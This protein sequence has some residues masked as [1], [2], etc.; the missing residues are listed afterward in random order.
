MNNIELLAPAG[1]Y[2][3]FVAALLGGADAVYLSGE[4]FGARAYAKNFNTEELVRAIEM[5]HILNKKVYLTVNTLVKDDELSELFDYLRPFYKAG[6]DGVIVQDIGVIDLIGSCFPDL[7]VHA[8]TQLAVTSYEGLKL[9]RRLGVKR[10][11]LAR[12]LTLSE[13]KNIHNKDDM[14][15][16]CF[17]H[18]ALCY[19]YSGKCLFSSMI[20]GRSG[21][22]GRCAGSCRQPYN[23]EKYLLSTK[24][25][26]C[27]K[28]IPELIDAG[29]VS[30]KIE[31]RMKSPDY[32][33]GVTKIYRKYIDLYLNNKNKYSVDEIR[34]KVFKNAGIEKDFD[35]LN[36]LYTRGGNSEGY[37]MNHNGRHMISISD[38]SYKSEKLDNI[39]NPY[40]LSNANYSIIKRKITG[41]IRIAVSEPVLLTVNYGDY[42]VTCYGNV[43][44]EAS[45]RPLEE[46]TVKKQIYKTGDS[47]F[48]FESLICDID[49]NCFLRVSE[50]NDIRRNALLE[51]RNKILSHTYRDNETRVEPKT[52]D[53]DG[54]DDVN[55]LE[56][57]PVSVS[58]INTEQLKIVS[59]FD[60]I[61]RVY[62]PYSLMGECI[63]NGLFNIL[64]DNHK[65]IFISFPS[66]IRYDY[67]GNNKNN[68][69]KYLDLSDGVLIDNNELLY[70]LRNE[71]YSKEIIGDIHVYG[72]NCNAVE[73]YKAL[74]VKRLTVPVELNRRELKN[75]GVESEE[76]IIYGYTPLM[77][78]AQCVNRTTEGC[79]KN[80]KY[81]ALKDRTGAV[82]TAVNDC[83]TCTNVIYNSVPVSLHNERELIE[84]LHPNMIRLTFSIESAEDTKS[85]MKYFE[86]VDFCNVH[87]PYKNFTK[88]HINRGVL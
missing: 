26:N 66:V 23:D 58:V 56:R 16:E 41:Y 63:D 53:G 44:D 32:V 55:C 62:I 84:G 15:L 70:F 48:E 38:A 34:N 85:I 35:I 17:I 30:F 39:H 51:L 22:R 71:G 68:I 82:F 78:S 67:L 40:S 33:Y 59:E 60:Y 25:I 12:E 7:A 11:V 69:L 36:R 74:G 28:L 20:G 83:E 79:D 8:S 43:V 4:K 42:S 77:I 31:G 19:S 54:K 29:I 52:Y 61:S 5:S 64:K 46:D 37:Y 50:L 21:N 6:L 47:E 49:G 45:N 10:T 24:D 86:Q 13:I 9:L 87:P 2:E 73:S 18:G 27:L 1:D 88:G 57:V 3:C 72:L 65:Q 14:E 81:I 75:R 80:K 76:L